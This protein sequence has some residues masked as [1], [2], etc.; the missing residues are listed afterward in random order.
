MVYVASER[1]DGTQVRRAIPYYEEA[2]VMFRQLCSKDGGYCYGLGAVLNNLAHALLEERSQPRAAK[3]ERVKA[4]LEEALRYR[5]RESD[6]AAWTTTTLLLARV[7]AERG[8]LSGLQPL[9]VQAA[10][11]VDEIVEDPMLKRDPGYD[12]LGAETQGLVHSMWQG[13]ER[14]TH[15]E[16]AVQLLDRAAAYYESTRDDQN[17]RR[18]RRDA[19]QLKLELRK[20]AKPCRATRLVTSEEH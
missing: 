11:T 13:P 19:W 7:Q 9:V 17:A 16:R 15:L 14:A 10:Q 5:T 1:G 12:V 6:L 3:L 20:A 8:K 4:L 2:E 18:C